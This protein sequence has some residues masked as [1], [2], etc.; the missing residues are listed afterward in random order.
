MKLTIELVPKTIWY[1]NLR[2][3]LSKAGWDK[4]R[5][6]A[7]HKADYHCEICGDQGPKWPVEC[8]EI[9]E[10]NDHSSVQTLKGLI[11]LCPD[12]HRVKHIGRAQI[13]GE[14]DLAL[15]HLMRV[16]ELTSGEA[17]HYIESCFQVWQERSGREWIQDL[18]W[19]EQSQGAEI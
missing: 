12:C 19:L 14:Y 8:H 15:K 10:Y 16:N 11:A 3:E 9:W 7:Y 2:S 4:L 18:S 17:E 6:A 13:V 1:S 5:K